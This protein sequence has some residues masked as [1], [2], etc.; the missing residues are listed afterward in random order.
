[1]WDRRRASDADAAERAAALNRCVQFASRPPC[2]FRGGADGFAC[3]SIVAIAVATPASPRCGPQAPRSPSVP[4]LT[5][6]RDRGVPAEGAHR[7]DMRDAGGG[8]T[9]S[10]RATLTDGTFVARRAHPDGGHRDAR[11]PGGKASETEFKDTY[12]FNIAGYRLARCSASEVPMSV[13]RRVDGSRRVGDVVGGRRRDGRE[14]PAQEEGVRP[15]SRAHDTADPVMRVWDELIQNK[16]RNQ[17]NILW[18]KDWTMWLIDHT[19]A[20]RLGPR[21]ARSRS[22]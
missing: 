2:A 18:T 19:R 12:R 15:Q 11:L 5:R 16:D 21:A 9:D 10:K 3:R 20:F 13:E 4:S 17:G 6:R 8:V 14:G 1:M 7:R 22:S